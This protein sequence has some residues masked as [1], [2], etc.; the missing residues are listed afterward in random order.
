[1]SHDEIYESFWKGIVEKDGVV[2]MDAVKRELADYHHVLCEVP[3]VYDEI[4]NGRLSKTNYFA[5]D[6]IA[7][8]RECFDSAVE[9]AVRDALHV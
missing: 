5:E 9:E 7:Q 6:V 3:K 8:Y 4:T 1:M 2:D